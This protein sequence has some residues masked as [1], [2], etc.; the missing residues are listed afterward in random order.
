MATKITLVAIFISRFSQDVKHCYRQRDSP[1]TNG[2]MSKYVRHVS[3][4]WLMLVVRISCY[5]FSIKLS[6]FSRFHRNSIRQLQLSNLKVA[7][8]KTSISPVD[9]HPRLAVSKWIVPRPFLMGGVLGYPTSFLLD[10]WQ[11]KRYEVL[12]LRALDN[13]QTNKNDYHFQN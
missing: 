4:F 9:F 13:G 8:A 2:V 3:L 10:T 11:A 5:E 7:S 1:L 12:P 6:F